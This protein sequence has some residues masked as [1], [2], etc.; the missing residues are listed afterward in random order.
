MPSGRCHCGAIAYRFEGPAHHASVCHCDDCRRCAGATGVAWIGVKAA[1][2]V[3]EQG[4]PVA[5]RSSADATRYFCGQCGTGLYYI[6][7]AYSP[8]AI[9]IQ[10]ATLDDPAAFPPQLHVQLADTVA[11][12]A[13]LTDLPGFARFPP[14]AP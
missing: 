6:N 9:D 5:Y 13:S 8:G 2:F 10:T 12:E 1:H 7:E 4:E 11:W 3:I 14:H